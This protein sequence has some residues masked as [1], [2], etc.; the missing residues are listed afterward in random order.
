MQS[1]LGAMTYPERAYRPFEACFIECGSG[2]VIQYARA[3]MNAFANNPSGAWS[4]DEPAVYSVSTDYGRTWTPWAWSGTVLHMSANNAKAVVINGIV[5]MVYGHRYKPDGSNLTMRY[6]YAKLDDAFVDNWADPVVIERGH[7]GENATMIT[8]G[9]Y[10]ALWADDVGNLLAVYYDADGSGGAYQANWR[11]CIGNPYVQPIHI[12]GGTG[13]KNVSYSQADVDKMLLAL[14]TELIEKINSII[15]ENGGTPDI[16]LDGS[17]Y[18]VDGLVASWDFYD[19][20][21][22]EGKMIKSTVG[23][24]YAS[25]SNDP[26]VSVDGVG[27]EKNNIFLCASNTVGQNNSINSGD[28]LKKFGIDGA[29]TIETVQ[30]TASATTRFHLDCCRINNTWGGIQIG[31]DAVPVP[32]GD[33]TS[34]SMA[35]VGGNPSVDGV[36][37]GHL[38][39][40]GNGTLKAYKNGQ[41]IGEKNLDADQMTQIHNIGFWHRNMNQGNRVLTRFYGK[42]LSDEEIQNNVTFDL[43]VANSQQT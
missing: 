35:S 26:A 41:Y 2:K 31:Y 3:S 5:H 21:K 32:A 14:K 34:V 12:A 18:V 7:W 9:G 30:Y 28:M 11:M 10:P 6:T 23:E 16:E 20:S 4:K 27:L 36:K 38:V 43:N 24:Y 37:V 1:T 25:A 17:F 42:A 33:G 40:D 8:D 19:L 39:Y 29:F 22:W 15:I 13:A